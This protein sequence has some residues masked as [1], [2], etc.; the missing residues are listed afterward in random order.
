MP[1]EMIQAKWTTD[2]QSKIYKDSL[3]IQYNVFI[4]EQKFPEGTN[5]DALEES[6]EYLVLYNQEHTPL[7]TARINK[8]E[9]HWYRVERV[10]VEKNARKLGLGKILIQKI[11]KRVLEN[12]GKAITLNSEDEAIGFYKKHNYQESGA[13]FLKYHVMHQKMIKTF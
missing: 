8:L 7:A 10:A 5:V 2:T 4:A 6:S 1:Q 12:G 11:E 3:D 13:Q 9:D